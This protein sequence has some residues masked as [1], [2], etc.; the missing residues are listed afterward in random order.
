MMWNTETASDAL[1]QGIATIAS[2][3]TETG[4]PII[5]D[6]LVPEPHLWHVVASGDA[7]I[8]LEA[9]SGYQAAKAYVDGGEW[10]DP[11]SGVTVEVKVW[12]EALDHEGWISAVN[13]EEH[14]ITLLPEEPPCTDDAHHWEGGC[15]S[16]EGTCFAYEHACSHCGLKRREVHYGSQRNCDEPEISIEY[17]AESL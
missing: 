14:S 11:G 7:E 9:R 5:D 4:W 8:V 6:C 12:Q 16:S 2:I 10:G 17:D 15:V 1:E 13:E 3:A